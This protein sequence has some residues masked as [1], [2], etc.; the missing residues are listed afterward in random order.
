MFH[1]VHRTALEVSNKKHW[2]EVYRFIGPDF[3]VISLEE[4]T[5]TVPVVAYIYLRM[6]SHTIYKF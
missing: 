6:I 2:E 1:I 5:S 4:K 3:D